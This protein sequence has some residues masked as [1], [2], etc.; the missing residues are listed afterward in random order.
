MLTMIVMI[1]IGAIERSPTG[2]GWCHLSPNSQL[3]TWILPLIL[4]LLWNTFFYFLILR[5]VWKKVN[6]VASGTQKAMMRL[7]LSGRLS[8]LLIV[9][10]VCWIFDLINHSITYFSDKQPP[11]WMIYL[12]DFFSPAQGFF[13]AILYGLTNQDFT[14]DFQERLL[15]CCGRNSSNGENMYTVV[16]YSKI[17]TEE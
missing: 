5:V 6:Q 4:T 17:Q 8:F 15:A 11:S 12:Q 3:I 1:S 16:K 14:F 13:N 9:F 7:Q 10:F 2:A